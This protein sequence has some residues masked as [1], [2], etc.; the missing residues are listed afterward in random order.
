[1]PNPSVIESGELQLILDDI[2]DRVAGMSDRGKVAQY[3]PELATVDLNQFGIAV[4]PVDGNPVSAGNADTLFSI[5]SISKVFSLTVA[6]KRVGATLWQRVGREPSGDPFNSIV[7]LEHERGIP[8]NPFINPGAIVVA[9]VLLEGKTANEAVEDVLAL[10]RDLAEDS[11]IQVDDAVADSEMRTGS[12]NRALA[13]F[14]EAEG[15]LRAPVEEV[16]SLYFR[17]C[18]IAMSCHQLA[19]AGRYLAAAGQ[20]P[21]DGSTV[22]SAQRARRVTA[23]MMMCGSYDAS[24]EFAFR[25]GL[26]AKS[27]VG[28]GILCIVPGIASVTAWSPGL[29]PKGNSHLATIAFQELVRATGWSVFGPNG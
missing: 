11:S 17:Q 21:V 20:N 5:Q 3:I 7:Q 29:D 27:G 2:A 19:V 16:L 4:A 9:D 23:L 28:G 1:M 26:P 25:V 14:M 18:S 6:L 22:L 24:G 8:R 12:R 10:C 13:H 15:N